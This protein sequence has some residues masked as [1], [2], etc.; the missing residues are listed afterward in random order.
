M[1]SGSAEAY[2]TVF[3]PAPP[4]ITEERKN[5]DGPRIWNDQL[6]QYAA[7]RTSDGDVDEVIGDPKNLRFTEMLTEVSNF[8]PSYFL[9]HL[10][11]QKLTTFCSPHS[12]LGGKALPMGKEGSMTISLLLY[13]LIQ[14]DHQSSLN[15]HLIV[16]HQY[17]FTTLDT[18]VS[19]IHFMSFRGMVD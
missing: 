14:R 19:D 4:K 3:K 13:K 15:F 10:V 17:R 12:G 16:H 9:I 6:L 18:Q 1:A 8:Q 5:L 7:W 11:V 2:I